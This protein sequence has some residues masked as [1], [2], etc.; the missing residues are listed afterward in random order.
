MN[1]SLSLL[2][3]ALVFILGLS[4]CTKMPDHARYIPKDAAFVVGVNTKELGKKVAWSKISGSKLLDDL[5]KSQGKE[6]AK[7]LEQAGIEGMSTT[8]MY[9]SP[10]KRY[11]NKAKMVVLLP[12]NDSKKWEAYLKK[13][14]PEATISASGKRSEAAFGDK[15]F[16]SWDEHLLMV[17]SVIAK[18]QQ[19]MHYEYADSTNRIVIDSY[20]VSEYTPDIAAM[21]AEM[22]A[23][24]SLKKENS[25][26]TDS[27][28]TRLE[29]AGHDITMWVNYDRLMSEMSENGLA[30]VLPGMNLSNTLWKE[31]AIAAG[32][33][34]EQGK[35]AGDMEYFVSN[36]MKEVYQEM[37]KKDVDQKMLE[38]LPGQNLDLLLGYH[39]S[40]KGLKMLLEKMGFLG[41]ANMALATQGFSVDQILESF[42]GDIVMSLNDFAVKPVQKTS[43]YDSTSYT[44]TEP[45]FNML[46]AF[47][48]NKKES[49]EKILQTLVSKEVLKSGGPGVYLPA[50]GNEGT[51]LLEGDYAVFSQNVE[52]A[53]AYIAGTA[54]KT[55]LPDAA[56][57][58]VSGHPFG[59]YADLQA[60]MKNAPTDG[61]SRDSLAITEMRKLLADASFNGGSFAGNSFKYHVSLNLV[62][63]KENSLVQFFDLAQRLN[64]ARKQMPEEQITALPDMSGQEAAAVEAMVDTLVEREGVE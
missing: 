53:K 32:F 43:Y 13:N 34:F 31:T 55:K 45:S 38:R 27:R 42:T 11:Q 56:L 60:F 4:A 52:L 8:Y 18:E 41:M 50:S 10:D 24:F 20:S 14:F 30:S 3:V 22:E 28:F 49:L 19:N 61:N 62:D 21:T 44:T 12:L 59:V 48:L 64:E 36:E 17:S 35:V 39:L 5:S 16:A 37:G 40:T 63:K 33:D 1:R 46:L 6:L 29:K 23:N 47:K 7:D 58:E 57:R 54:N 2:A 9:I 25:I 51:L 26:T 15:A